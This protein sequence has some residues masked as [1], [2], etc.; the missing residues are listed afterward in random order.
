MK[1][2]NKTEASEI[3]TDGT[4]AAFGTFARTYGS[5]IADTD[6]TFTVDKK[7]LIIAHRDDLKGCYFFHEGKKIGRAHV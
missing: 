2:A 3:V 4:L 7:N 1:L 6:T 5:E